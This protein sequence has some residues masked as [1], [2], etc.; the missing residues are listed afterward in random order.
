MEG[1][2]CNYDS[3]GANWILK[4]HFHCP[5]EMNDHLAPELA[6]DSLHSLIMR[7]PTLG[8]L[9]AEYIKFCPILNHTRCAV[10]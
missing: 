5:P 3:E 7:V 9:H 1:E 4:S 6:P 8:G 2:E 10:E